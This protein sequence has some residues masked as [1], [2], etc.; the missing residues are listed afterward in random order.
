MPA[1]VPDR[2]APD[3]YAPYYARYINR[4]PTGDLV[5]LLAAQVATFRTTFGAAAEPRAGFR[6]APGKWSLREVIGHLID[7]ERVF[8]FRAIS[9]AR[10]DQ[11]PLPSFDQ[12]AWVPLAHFDARP[13]DSLVE[14]WSM[15]RAATIAMVRGLPDDALL[16]R[17]IASDVSFTVRALLHIPHGHLEYHVEHARTHYG[18]G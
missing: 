7:T 13:L 2:P 14:E 4:V 3:E 11:H 6:Y 16:R 5:A 9:F 1:S 12:D 18:V 10:G 17:G 15:Q 8:T